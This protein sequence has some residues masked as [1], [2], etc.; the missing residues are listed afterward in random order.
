MCRAPLGQRAPR[1]ARHV[2][3]PHWFVAE[4]GEWEQREPGDT[5]SWIDALLRIAVT[6][7]TLVV[8]LP[9]IVGITDRRE[10]RRRVKIVHATMRRSA[11]RRALTIH[12][13]Q[14][15]DRL[16]FSVPR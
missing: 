12:R 9:E 11:L 4:G 3:R 7:E 6:G 14:D 8:D 10:R 16:W 2:T 15:G 1:T 5:A 13:H